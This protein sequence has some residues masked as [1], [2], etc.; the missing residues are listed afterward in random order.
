M[1]AATRSIGAR[2]RRA[3]ITPLSVIN[4]TLTVNPRT[5]TVTP[6]G[7]T[8]I[9]GDANPTFTYSASGLVNGDILTGALATL[10]TANSG[11]GTYA[12]TGGTLGA[13]GN[14]TIGYAP[15][16]LSVT[17]RAITVTADDQRR[18]Y[19]TQNPVF[20]Y[21]VTGLVNGDSLGGALATSATGISDPGTYG[22]TQGTL[23]SPNYL[24][25]YVPAILTIDPASTS[26]P[27]AGGIEQQRC[28]QRLGEHGNRRCSSGSDSADRLRQCPA[29]RQ[30][31]WSAVDK[32]RS[33]ARKWCSGQ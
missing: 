33:L 8:R 4:G 6:D 3:A 15:A 1:S 26:S 30:R 27:G 25:D 17:P 2:S 28:G 7:V 18:L 24:I 11:V 16:S 23:G 29:D 14:Y 20:T 13:G 12:I 5:I 21:R 10:A 9:Y 22:I 19:G 32:W 31:Q